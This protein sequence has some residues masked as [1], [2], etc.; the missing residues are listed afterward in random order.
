MRALNATATPGM[1]VLSL[2]L[3]CEKANRQESSRKTVCAPEH[4]PV[5]TAATRTAVGAA[6]AAASSTTVA[7]GE[8]PR[9]RAC[10][11]SRRAS[12]CFCAICWRM[13]STPTSH[14]DRCGFVPVHVVKLPMTPIA[15][16]E[17][18]DI[19][20]HSLAPRLPERQCEKRQQRQKQSASI[21]FKPAVLLQLK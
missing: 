19:V 6:A 7:R 1:F 17:T 15:G 13:K 11:S 16:R 2:E 20:K 10:I 3:W 5:S 18:E 14:R 9:T 4:P 21:R 12:L 8:R